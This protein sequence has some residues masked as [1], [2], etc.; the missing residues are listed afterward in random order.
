MKLLEKEEEVD[1]YL[2]VPPSHSGEVNGTARCFSPHLLFSLF[3]SHPITPK[4]LNWPKCNLY[5]VFQ[6]SISTGCG[7][8]GGMGLFELGPHCLAQR[9]NGGFSF[10]LGSRAGQH[11]FPPQDTTNV[12]P[13]PFVL[14]FVLTEPCSYGAQPASDSRPHGRLL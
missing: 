2:S 3:V 4:P 8:K 10:P 9:E 5:A 12:S 14:S 6:S 1:A 13:S 7:N 11:A